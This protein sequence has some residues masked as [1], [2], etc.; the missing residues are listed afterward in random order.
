MKNHNGT[1]P[2]KPIQLPAKLRLQLAGQSD[3][4]GSAEA[5]LHDDH[6]ISAGV[7]L[8][9]FQAP[10]VFH[11][12]FVDITGS[13]TAA[14]MLSHAVG[15]TDRDES[16]DGWFTRPQEAWTAEI[17]LSRFEQQ[18]ARKTL[19][20]LNLLFESRHGSPPVIMYKVNAE[21]VWKL[22]NDQARSKWS[23]TQP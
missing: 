2:D 8:D 15:I 16:S 3:F 5:A 1:Y 6:H 12:T 13:V 23:K 18:G 20:G 22:V 4:F 19:L 21:Q 10:I 17:G 9:C 11:R 7:I 14:L